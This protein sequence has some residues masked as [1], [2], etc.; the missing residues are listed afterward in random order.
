MDNLLLTGALLFAGYYYL[1][2]QNNLG[3]DSTKPDTS[4]FPMKT[5]DFNTFVKNVQNAII[6]KGGI[7][8]E[9]ILK[10]GG[11]NGK[12]TKEV[13]NALHVLGFPT[14]LSEK[15]YRNLIDNTLIVRNRAYVSAP[16]GTKIFAAVG[17]TYLPGYAYG[18]EEITG[19]PYRTYLG[20][21]TG[22]FKNDMLEIATTINTQ[23]IKFWVQTKDIKLVSKEEY[24]R[25]RQSEI[26]EKSEKVKQKLLN[27]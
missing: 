6:N 3:S 25:L 20:I 21:A 9:L 10:S 7:A 18:R 11:A 24:E 19:L 26:L 13:A 14:Q 12:F 23:K 15:D 5:G 27:S 16:N 8:A 4:I 22:R 2:K 17:D 1:Q